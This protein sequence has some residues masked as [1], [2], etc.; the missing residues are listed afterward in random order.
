MQPSSPPRKR[1]SIN[2][3]T[4]Y[5][6]L[7]AWAKRLERDDCAAILEQNLQEEQVADHR[8]AE[9]AECDAPPT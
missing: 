9:L 3:I 6:S 7:I 2:E 5:G 4:R 1:S 8:L